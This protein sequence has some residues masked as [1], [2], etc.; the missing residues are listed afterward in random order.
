MHVDKIIMIR[1]YRLLILVVSH[2]VS[3][4]SDTV[5]RGHC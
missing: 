5:S 1:G 3:F 4:H 2:P